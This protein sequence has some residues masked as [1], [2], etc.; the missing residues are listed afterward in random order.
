VVLA[1]DISVSASAR[2]YP[3]LHS[4]QSFVR[5][6]ASLFLYKESPKASSLDHLDKWG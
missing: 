5:L 2:E 4:G 3:I 1:S 6:S